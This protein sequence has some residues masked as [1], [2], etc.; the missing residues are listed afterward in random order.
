VIRAH[1]A[2]AIAAT[3]AAAAVA[4]VRDTARPAAATA[5]LAGRVVVAGT[6]QSARRAR[7]TLTDVTR[8]IPG[9]TT[10]TDDNGAFVFRAVAPG[11]YD[12]Q[13]FKNGY[14]RSSYG[15][16]RP[17][18]A[19]TPV[20]VKEHDA[21][22]N[23]TM[24]IAHGGVITGAVRDAR[25]R[26][27]PGMNVRVLKLGYDAV[28]GEPSLSVPST[29]VVSR[30]DDRGEYRAFGLPPGGYIVMVTPSTGRSLG[31]GD[32]I[33]QPN[34]VRVTFAP[35]FHPGASDVSA[36]A[37]IPLGVGEE[38][39]GI[40]VIVQPLPTA[41]VSGSITSSSGE[42]PSRPSVRLVPAGPRANLLAAAGLPLPSAQ[43][44]AGATYEVAGVAPG[45]YTVRA[46]TGGGRGRLGAAADALSLS[47]AV[48]IVVSGQDLDV[49]LT[50]QPD[51]AVHGRVTFDGEPPSAGEL[52]K[53]SFSLVPLASGGTARW[54]AGG[55]V[56]ADGH[57][58][59]AGVPPDSYR[60]VETW[61]SPGADE[62]W[63]ITAAT[64]NGRDVLDSP[65]RVNSNE[66]VEWTIAY[67]SRPSVVRGVFA[68]RSG[69][70]ATDYTVLIFPANRQFWTPGS[71]R[72]RL[73][74][75]ATDGAFRVAGLP[76]GDYFIAAL[77]D[78]EP[79]EWND[80]TVL[81]SLVQWSIRIPVRDGETTTQDVR[82]G[83]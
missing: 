24:T 68:D 35:V 63:S 31:P 43:P 69:R 42:L 75:P 60:F 53:L 5:S 45:S 65:L 80:P 77:A 78:L 72:V 76:A 34:G 83:G 55:H 22:T 32:D 57:F 4:Q 9:Q 46:S 54:S 66:P 20:V 16:A 38:R 62:K 52:Q 30:T 33:R 51:A 39:T 3:L 17:D 29:S 10:T 44:H 49:P 79:G 50:L 40:D 21:L 71:R 8:A 56:D 64:A 23:L 73:T 12:L 19:G 70:P 25:G 67:S 28:T 6:P 47:A 2:V 36:A 1:A 7:V 48:D 74:R 18:R 15:A 27:I 14:L 26:P 59:F 82:V 58:A 61:N 37:T 13:A 81:A 41:T 11:R